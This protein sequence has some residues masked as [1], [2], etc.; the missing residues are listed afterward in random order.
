MN[1]PPKIELAFLPTPIHPAKAHKNLFF[2]RDDHTGFCFGGNKVR[3]AEYIIQDALEKKATHLLMAGNTNSNYIRVIFAAA[4]ANGII[5]V[6]CFYGSL[7]V[8]NDG[9]WKITKA[10]GS[11]NFFSDNKDRESSEELAKT[12]F[13]QLSISGHRPYFLPRGG[14]SVEAVFGYIEF[15]DELQKQMAELSIQRLNLVVPVGSGSTIAGIW[16]GISALELD[17]NVIGICTSRP[18]EESKNKASGL[19]TRALDRIGISQKLSS[20]VEFMDQWNSE[21]YGQWSAELAKVILQAI[22]SEGLILDPI[23]TGKAYMGLL[24]LLKQGKL[25]GRPTVFLHCGG[26][27]SLFLESFEF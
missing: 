7:P 13:A 12:V 11:E 5:P 27:P 21:G 22:V 6:G 9:N 26:A 1:L 20:N 18:K 2:K 25:A 17:W 16:A 15:V 8:R 24:E 19:A 10:L 4:R 23:F 14:A 3:C